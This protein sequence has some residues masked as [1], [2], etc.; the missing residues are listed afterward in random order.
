MCP[1]DNPCATAGSGAGTGPGTCASTAAVT[2]NALAAL[3]AYCD[4]G[5]FN[6]AGTASHVV[7]G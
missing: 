2:T 3:Y 6:A 5:A 4:D 1:G 7:D